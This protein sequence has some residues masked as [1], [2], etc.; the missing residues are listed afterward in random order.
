MLMFS[1]KYSINQCFS[2][3]AKMSCNYCPKT[4][5]C[6][7]PPKCVKCCKAATI[8]RS[9][10]HVLH[11]VP[12]PQHSWPWEPRTLGTNDVSSKNS[13]GIPNGQEFKNSRIHF[14]D[15]CGK[16][17]DIFAG[18][19]NLQWSKPA[20]G[21]IQ[22]ICNPANLVPEM[23]PLMSLTLTR[24]EKRKEKSKAKKKKKQNDL[25]LLLNKKKHTETFVPQ[26]ENFYVLP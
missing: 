26:S 18:S 24:K 16:I 23:V 7:C 2:L 19:E 22:Q 21:A 12:Q 17:D 1:Y 9:T 10:I 14:L 8:Y 5:M 4:Y 15:D 11:G 6:Q 25:R 13:N 20:N 3:T